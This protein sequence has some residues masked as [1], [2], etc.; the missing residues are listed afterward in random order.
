MSPLFCIACLV[1]GF[2]LG[3]GFTL[4][5]VA[6][7]RSAAATSPQDPGTLIMA[8][9]AEMQA[10]LDRL[11]QIPAAIEAAKANAAAAAVA[12]ANAHHT[13]EVAALTTATDA[14]VNAAQ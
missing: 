8:I 1:A 7:R 14:V 2:V 9:S 12:Q 6:A 11:A 4:L 10:Q 5:F 3:N 13:E